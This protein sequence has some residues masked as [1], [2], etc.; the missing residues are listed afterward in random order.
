MAFDGADADIREEIGEG[1]C[2]CHG[3]GA[4]DGETG[5]FRQIADAGCDIHGVA[6]CGVLVAFARTQVVISSSVDWVATSE[7]KSERKEL[8]EMINTWREDWE[9]RD[10]QRYARHYS[11]HFDTDGQN[12]AAWI[13]QKRRVNEAKSWIKVDTRNVSM[14]RN[15]GRE[16]Y[17]VVTFEQDYRSSNL[18]NQMMKRQYWIRE[19]G[20]WKI[21]HEGAA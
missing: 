14:F 9:S 19:D 11:K 18:S 20:R 7:W 13:D 12:Y 21:V 15:P 17:V 6:D 4:D 3:G 8:V 16:E 1:Q 10:I 5:G 2:R